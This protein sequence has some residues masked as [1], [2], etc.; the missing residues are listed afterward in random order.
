MF[1]F[2]VERV[3]RFDMGACMDDV[4]IL[5]RLN[6]QSCLIIGVFESREAA[7]A[8]T[9]KNGPVE[10]HGWIEPR[11]G[12]RHWQYDTDLFTYYLEKHQIRAEVGALHDTMLHATASNG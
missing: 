11:P 1:S 9:D 2:A 6:H 5:Y 12:Q 10:R 8:Y 4:W 7:F 3:D